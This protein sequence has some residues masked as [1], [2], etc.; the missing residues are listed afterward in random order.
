MGHISTGNMGSKGADCIFNQLYLSCVLKELIV[1]SISYM[2]LCSKGAAC[3]FNQLYFSCV[4][5]ELI[6]S[7]I[8]YMSLG[9]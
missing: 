2:Y 7:S 1:S 3:I 4:L 5:K 8:S 9:S 6:A